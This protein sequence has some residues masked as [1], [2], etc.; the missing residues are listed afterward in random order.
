MGAHQSDR[1]SSSHPLT[2]PEPALGI[3]A[4]VATEVKKTG[5]AGNTRS[6]GIP[7]MD[8]GRLMAFLKKKTSAKKARELLNLSR[9]QLKIMTELLTGH[10]HLNG[11]LFKL[12]LINSPECDRCKQAS[13]M[14]S[15]SL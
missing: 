12:G 10:C 2:G 3:S 5:H 1:D 7:Y 13:E 11:Y 15:H 6:I 8:K 4:K 9:N 14:A